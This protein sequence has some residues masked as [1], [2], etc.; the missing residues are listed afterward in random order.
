[1]T[2]TE[3]E[4]IKIIREDKDPSQALQIAMSI[5]IDHLKQSESFSAPF[6]SAHQESA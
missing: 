4:L 2:T 5:I 6:P 1:M 3:K